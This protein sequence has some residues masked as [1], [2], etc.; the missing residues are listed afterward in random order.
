MPLLD[1]V[2]TSPPSRRLA[3]ARPALAPKCQLILARTLRIPRIVD[4]ELFRVIREI[5]GEFL[6][7]VSTSIPRKIGVFPTCGSRCVKRR[8]PRPISTSTSREKPAALCAL[9]YPRDGAA[10][11]WGSPATPAAVRIVVPLLSGGA[12]FAH[13]RLPFAPL[14]RNTLPARRVEMQSPM[15][16]REG[17]S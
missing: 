12:R 14:G 10:G 1:D 6:R 8:R 16:F 4:H 9:S 13:P 17:H 3:S 5:R 15:G 2:T 7:K 11:A